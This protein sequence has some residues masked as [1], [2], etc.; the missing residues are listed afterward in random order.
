MAGI[1]QSGEAVLLKTAGTVHL[2][3]SIS[4]STASVY[5]HSIFDPAWGATHP[6][7]S[8]QL[9]FTL[10]RINRRAMV[11]ARLWYVHWVPL[12]T[13]AGTPPAGTT[14]RFRLSALIGRVS[15]LIILMV[16]MGLGDARESGISVV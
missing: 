11:E 2:V 8:A 9:L 10:S 14:I 16:M 12:C 6:F 5:V 1:V 15:W 4:P 7:F 3:S 13:I